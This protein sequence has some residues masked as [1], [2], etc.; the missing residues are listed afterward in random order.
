MLRELLD[1]GKN[2]NNYFGMPLCIFDY[3]NGYYCHHTHLQYHILYFTVHFH[4]N[5]KG[6]SKLME[7]HVPKFVPYQNLNPWDADLVVFYSL[8]IKRC[9]S[10]FS[11]KFQC[12]IQLSLGILFDWKVSLWLYFWLNRPHDSFAL[13]ASVDVFGTSSY[14]V[15]KYLI[16][17]IIS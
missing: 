9:R 4:S 3:G 13:L 1:W 8:A 17:S 14:P 7:T 15:F 2:W 6:L 12:Q 11:T 10:S 16:F 5:M